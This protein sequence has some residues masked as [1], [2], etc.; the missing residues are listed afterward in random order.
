MMELNNKEKII[1]LI[2][3][4]IFLGVFIWALGAADGLEHCMAGVCQYK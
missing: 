4:F 2:C 3:A 1:L